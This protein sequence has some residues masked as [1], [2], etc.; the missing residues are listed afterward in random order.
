MAT[1]VLI[2]DD[3]H[4]FRARARLLLES[5]GYAVIGEA[6]DGASALSAASQLRPDLVVLDVML[7]DSNG[8]EITER[9]QG[10]APTPTV[11]LVSS[12]EA[13]DFGRLLE[14]SRAIGFITKPELSG[15]RLRELLEPIT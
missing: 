10:L 7:P 12:N 14:V 1:T 2:V 3:H 15:A 4:G 8:F 9:L 5:E 11:V 6:T 13:V